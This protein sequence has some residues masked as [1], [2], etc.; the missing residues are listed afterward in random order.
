MMAVRPTLPPPARSAL[1]LDLDGTLLDIAPTPDSVV[2]PPGLIAALRGLRARLGDAV[3]VITGRPVEQVDA[4]LDAVPYAVSGEHGSATRFAPGA[5]PTHENL[6]SVPTGWREQAERIA[7]GHPGLLLE[8]KARGFG[9]HYRAVP[10]LGPKIHDALAA[11][12]A[13]SQDFALLQGHKLW[14]VRPR[15]VHKGTA[16]AALM[17]R[18]PFAGR[19]PIFIGDDVTDEDAIAVAEAMGGVGLRVA[20]AFTDPAGVRAWLA[21]A[22]RDADGE[23]W[24]AP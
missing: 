21:A 3:A 11:L 24:P 18:P 1:L 15:G 17:A 2:V 5:A 16:V 10:A 22:A 9:L 14:E 4:L 13:G 20:D 12:V 19:L 8:Q 23:S 7:A 6:P